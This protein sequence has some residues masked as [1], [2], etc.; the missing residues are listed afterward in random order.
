MK[1]ENTISLTLS[2]QTG[3]KTIYS[4]KNPRLG[5]QKERHHQFVWRNSQPAK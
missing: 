4:I 2:T 3:E 1:T 5:V